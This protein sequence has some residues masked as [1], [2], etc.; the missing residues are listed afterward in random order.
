ML[1]DSCHPLL[2]GQGQLFAEAAFWINEY[3]LVVGSWCS[4]HDKN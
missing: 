2:I 1:D 4:V 3:Y